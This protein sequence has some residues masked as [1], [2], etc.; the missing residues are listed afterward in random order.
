MMTSSNPCLAGGVQEHVL[1]LS[2]ELRKRGH[3][4]TIYGPKPKGKTYF[5]HYRS[6]GEKVYFPLP[7]GKYSNIH[8]LQESDKPTNIFIKKKYDI[9]HIHEPYIPFAAW[10]VLEKIKIPVV[11]TFHTV[12]DNESFFNIF[13]Q[14]IPLFSTLFSTYT[15][16][17][18]FVSN[19]CYEKWHM[20]CN[21]SVL[22]SIIPNA[23]DTDLFLPKKGFNKKIELLFVARLVHRKGLLRLLKALTIVKKTTTAFSLTII[24]DGDERQEDFEYIRIHKL[25]KHITYLGEITGKKRA[26]YFKK[27]DVFCAPYTNEASSLSVLEA[28]SAGLP[29]VGYKIPIF[30]DILKDYPGAELLVEKN[31]A[32]LAKGLIKIISNETLRISLKEW[33]MKKR[34]S[35]SWQSVAKRTEELY[36]QTIKKYER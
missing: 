17:A 24:G 31:D 26:L 22:K 34:S 32:A 3:S 9:I 27:A 30:S 35:F 5:T 12:W 14:L 18:I 29:V 6:L 15:Q 1:A 11:G 16:A 13:N 28:I 25:R 20:L 23:V 10:N 36:Y 21:S 8:L 4:V 2:R 19:I 33:C 7:N